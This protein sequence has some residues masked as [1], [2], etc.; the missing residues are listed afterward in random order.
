MGISG[1]KG[2]FMYKRIVVKV[3][4][5]LLVDDKGVKRDFYVPLCHRY[6]HFTQNQRK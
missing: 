3:G 5:N 4:T 6:R 1:N 2:Y